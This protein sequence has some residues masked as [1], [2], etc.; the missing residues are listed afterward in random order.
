[1]LE[2]IK[3]ILNL[4]III[5]YLIVLDKISTHSVYID[6]KVVKVTVTVNMYLSPISMQTDKYTPIYRA[7][8]YIP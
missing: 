2:S 3:F 6:W 5:L 8:I 7:T 4:N 1:L